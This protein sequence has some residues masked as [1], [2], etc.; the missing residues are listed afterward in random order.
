[1]KEDVPTAWILLENGALPDEWAA[2]SRQVQMVALTPEE[3]AQ[4]L[5]HKQLAHSLPPDDE[6]LLRLCAQGLSAPQIAR[7]LDMSER[8]VERRLERLRKRFDVET[9]PALVSLLARSG[10]AGGE[11]SER[12]GGAATK[13]K[14]LAPGNQR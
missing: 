4:V 14:N 1:M 10:W 11:S 9:T 5:Q 6:K 13:M 7:R 3:T 12:V 2:R 8:T